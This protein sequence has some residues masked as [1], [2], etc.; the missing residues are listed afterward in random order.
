MNVASTMFIFTML[1]PMVNSYV[2][3]TISTQFPL[4]LE[5]THVQL[6]AIAPM[7]ELYTFRERSSIASELPRVASPVGLLRCWHK[8]VNYDKIRVSGDGHQWLFLLPQLQWQPLCSRAPNCSTRKQ[9]HG[10]INIEN[11]F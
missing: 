6:L 9:N 1:K 2:G 11:H 4:K 8:Q 5:E 3:G 7:Q 10:T